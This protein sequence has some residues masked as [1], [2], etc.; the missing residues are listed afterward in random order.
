[1]VNP[2]VHL[3]RSPVAANTFIKAMPEVLAWF[4]MTIKNQARSVM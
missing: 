2:V 3:P 4:T 1:V